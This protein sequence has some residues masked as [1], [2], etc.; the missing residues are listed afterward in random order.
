MADNNKP[1][2]TRAADILRLASYVIVF[3]FLFHPVLSSN[4]DLPSA[5]TQKNSLI[6]LSDTQAPL[7]L[8][9]LLLKEDH[10]EEATKKILD[11]ILKETEMA[12]LF[13]LGDIVAWSSSDKD[14]RPMDEA[15]GRLRKLNVPIYP[16]MGNHEYLSHP[17]EGQKNFKKRFPELSRSWY[18]ARIGPIAVIMLNSNFEWLSKT[19]RTEQE[20]FYETEMK[21]LEA[22]PAIQGILV[23]SHNPPYT[24][25]K[26]V[27]PSKVVEREFVPQFLKSKKGMLFM[28]GHA[29]AAEDFVREGKHFLVLGGGGGLLHP[30][31]T[32]A[33]Q[34]YE[35][36]FPIKTERRFFHYVK[37]EIEEDSIVVTYK[38]LTADFADFRDVYQFSIPFDR[39]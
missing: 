39:S 26:I 17:R 25:S 33:R 2:K 10:N 16:A 32:G 1:T 13:Y 28:S 5:E 6:F 36:H 20:A 24:N 29:H 27:N 7:F 23:C 14:W 22:D 11:N 3:G 8:E 21:T 9:T 35:D 18:S 15:F 37:L 12:A 19:E 31:L 34:R 30:L 38:M 4:T